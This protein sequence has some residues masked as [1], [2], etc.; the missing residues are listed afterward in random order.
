MYQTTAWIL[1]FMAAGLLIQ[2]IVAL[3]IGPANYDEFILYMT[4][5][6]RF[7]DLIWQPW[8]LVTWPFF[9]SSFSFLTILFGGMMLFTFGRIHQQFLNDTRTRRLVMLA[10]PL[11]GLLTVTY[12]TVRLIGSDA[13]QAI[14]ITDSNNPQ[15]ESATSI[16]QAETSSDTAVTEETSEEAK[17]YVDSQIQRWSRQ[18]S[19]VGGIIPL[20]ILLMISSIT[21]VPR[22]PIRLFLFGQV[23][24]RIVGLIFF[25]LIW[26]SSGLFTPL[27]FA[28][29]LAGGLG[30]LNVYLMR[31]GT[32]VTE[33][34]WSFYKEEKKPRMKVKY[35]NPQNWNNGGDKQVAT[36]T[37][38]VTAED[39]NSVPEEMV[40]RILEKIHASGYDSLS[41]EE[42]ELLFKASNTKDGSKD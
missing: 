21:L 30:Y 2:G 42:K 22:Y 33:I 12:S 38:I 28:V 23:E 31:N 4:L 41:R 32:D 34:I 26:V 40:D 17:T 36:K 11:L 1:L 10:I 35:S 14:E 9:Y 5:P 25:G 37:K 20:M 7:Q 24:I 15:E 8:S 18:G 6:A 13:P 16:D 27:G 19:Y 29:L 39:G 3:A